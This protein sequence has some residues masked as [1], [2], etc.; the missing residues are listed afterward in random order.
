MPRKMLKN[1]WGRLKYTRLKNLT[2]K[3]PIGKE[4][5]NLDV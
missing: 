3:G 5:L 1:G 2:D 4:N